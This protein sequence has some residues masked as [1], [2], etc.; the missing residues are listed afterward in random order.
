MSGFMTLCPAYVVPILPK[1]REII[2]FASTGG[3]PGRV[4]HKLCG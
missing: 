1:G 2:A 3:K 4:I